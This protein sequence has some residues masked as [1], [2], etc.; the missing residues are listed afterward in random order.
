MVHWAFK[1]PLLS[2]AK[3]GGVNGNLHAPLAAQP[4]PLLLT[5]HLTLILVWKGR[6]KE[7]KNAM[8]NVKRQNRISLP[9]FSFQTVLV[10]E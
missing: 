8:K 1:G 5:D 7:K 3:H 2:P 10:I 6:G 9:F 4:H